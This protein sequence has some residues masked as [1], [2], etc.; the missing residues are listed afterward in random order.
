MWY[1]INS[2]LSL[3]LKM[4]III[5]FTFRPHSLR[6][7]FHSFDHMLYK[8]NHNDMYLQYNNNY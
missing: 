2:P 8:N 5:P 1:P 4:M 3:L 6:N 7:I